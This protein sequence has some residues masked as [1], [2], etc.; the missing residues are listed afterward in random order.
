MITLLEPPRPAGLTSGGFRYQERV[1]G[2]LGADARRLTVAPGALHDRVRELRAAAPRAVVVVDGW[3]ADLQDRPLP[4]GVI[5]LLH[6]QPTTAGWA[7]DVDRAIVT[8][9]GTADGLRADVARIAVV[10][11]GIDGCFAP[12]PRTGDATPGVICTGT[13]CEAKGQRR[14]VEAL[15]SAPAPWRLTIVGSASRE[16]DYVARLRDV[17]ADSPVT[18]RDAVPPEMLAALYAEHDLFVSMSTRESYGMAAAE[19]AAAGLPLFGLDT[20]EL[21]AFGDRDARWLLPV[22]ADD[23]AVSATLHA[24]LAAPRALADCR[25]TIPGERRSWRKVA[26]E[27]AAACG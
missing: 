10:R 25:R 21:R 18:I 15:R 27:F 19:A 1:V 7:A 9:A 8:G 2:A 6:M 24:L 5:A 22:D 20:G 13:I 16:P 17:A 26:D 4:A 23:A 11:P 12:G 3:F 14:L